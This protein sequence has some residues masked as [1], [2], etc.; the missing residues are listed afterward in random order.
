[1]S[2]WT[3]QLGTGHPGWL[4]VPLQVPAKAA[5]PD[6]AG[7]EDGPGAAGV[8][9]GGLGACECCGGRT[10]EPA[11]PGPERDVP[12]VPLLDVGRARGR[13][14]GA[15]EP[16]AATACGPLR[17]PGEPS[18]TGRDRKAMPAATAPTSTTS[19]TAPPTKGFLGVRW[20]PRGGAPPR[21]GGPG[22]PGMAAARRASCPPA[23]GPA[24][25]GSPGAGTAADAGA[26]RTRSPV[27]GIQGAEASALD[28]SGGSGTDASAP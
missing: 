24:P 20:P 3:S 21:G 27:F 22:G 8:V 4:T 12:V 19:A 1:M 16:G 5:R 9:A 15:A 17:P 23:I 11:G 25:A 2:S 13:R 14:A 28:H 10:E 7:A 18:L 6:G 26:A